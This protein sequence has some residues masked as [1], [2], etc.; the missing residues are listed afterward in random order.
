M[1]V[2]INSNYTHKVWYYHTTP[3]FYHIVH[4][5][6]LARVSL[7]KHLR[8]QCDKMLVCM[9]QGLSTGRVFCTPFCHT[10][11]YF[12]HRTYIHPQAEFL[13]SGFHTFIPPATVQVR[14]RCSPDHSLHPL[15]QSQRTVASASAFASVALAL[16]A[17]TSATAIAV[18]VTISPPPLPLPPHFLPC[19]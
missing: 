6:L 15:H 14:R 9:Y 2:R 12:V 19:I 16:A 3:A 7:T 4:T 13:A 10:P 1:G 11:L 18:I 5:I 8:T 17:A